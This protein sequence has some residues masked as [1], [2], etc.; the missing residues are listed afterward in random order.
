MAPTNR[1]SK[2]STNT[3]SSSSTTSPI[4]AGGGGG[5]S[6]ELQGQVNNSNSTLSSSS[7]TSPEAST[8]T[9]SKSKF[10]SYSLS[11]ALGMTP[12]QFSSIVCM[13][14]GMTHG[15]DV[16]RSV[17]E[18]PTATFCNRHFAYSPQQIDASADP[19]F[20]TRGD[21]AIMQLKYQTTVIRIILYFI[22][23]MLCWSNESLLKCWNFANI[24]SPLG[25]SLMGLMIQKDNLLA[26]EKFSLM[27]LLVLSF[28][29]NL[30]G[31]GQRLGMN[32]KKG[33]YNLTLF[34]TTNIWSFVVANHLVL[35]V[36]GYTV[37]QCNDESGDDCVSRGGKALWFMM[38]LVDYTC[39]M[40]TCTFGLFYLDDVRKR[41]LLF[42]MAILMLF[43]AFYQL[44]LQK[45]I[46]QDPQ[47]R[48]NASMG[49]FFVFVVSALIPSFDKIV[50]KK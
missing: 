40:F 7:P 12:A 36:E 15:L 26:Q 25:T 48:Q 35:N 11:S 29:S 13:S 37:F 47:G 32:L 30:D 31:R 18:G 4:T 44:P 39:F 38:V 41:V 17:E 43:H 3:A 42:C 34:L 22:T 6:V 50:V 23:M 10:P 5:G 19:L 2:R 20:C 1:R 21:L 49:Y 46:W 9:S 14:I 27:A 16:Y 8:T 33:L 28:S 24:I 45:D